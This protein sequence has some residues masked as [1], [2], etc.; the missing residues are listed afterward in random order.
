MRTLQET[1][2]V[3]YSSLSPGQQKVAAFYIERPQEAALLTAFQIGKQV[4]VSETT[5]IRLAYALGFSGYSEL[6]Q[7]LRKDWLLPKQDISE[8]LPSKD[9]QT[10][11]NQLIR[12][13]ILREQAILQNL[14]EQI[15]VDDVWAMAETLIHSDRIYIGGFGSSYA[16]AYWLYYALKQMRGNVVISSPTGFMTEDICDLTTNSAAVI[17]SFPRYRQD[18]VQ[19]A[20]IAK[21]QGA[22]I[23]GITDRTLSPIGQLADMTFTSSENEV[24]D[25]HSIASIISL[26][27]M[28]LAGM[29]IRDCEH[30]AKRQQ[31][32]EHLYA[33]QQLFSE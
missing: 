25:A 13:V 20:T 17:F 33:E 24:T 27:D 11:D 15:K 4:G 18:T 12:Q 31:Q 9:G 32:L 30:I 8:V 7:A 29:R 16:A 5:V 23:I 28:L 19:A 22:K 6:Q 10:N 1:I 3:H 26:L 21:E 14:A 2:K